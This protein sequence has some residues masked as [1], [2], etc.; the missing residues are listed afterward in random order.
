[1]HSRH[2]R[3]SLA[4]ALLAVMATAMVL[5]GAQKQTEE[6][7]GFAVRRPV[8][9]G[10]CA[11][12][13][14]GALADIV[15]E[16]LLPYGYNAKV[17][18]DCS[19]SYGPPLVAGHENPRHV[20]PESLVISDHSP[21]LPDAPVDFGV[22]S[23]QVLYN[24]YHGLAPYKQ[25]MKNLRLL[26]NLQSPDFLIVAVK[27]DTGIT[28]LSQLRKKRW[29]VRILLGIDGGA[30]T[31]I[32]NYYGLT[33]KEIVSAGGSIASAMSPAERRNFDVV[34]SGGN[35][36][37]APEYNVWYEVSQKYDLTYLQ[38]PNDLLD[39]LAKDF[40]FQRG[41]IPDG[42]LRGITH[43]IATVVRTGTVVFGRSD[44][45]DDFAYTVAKA[46]DVHQALLQWSNLRFSYNIHTVWKDRDVPLA[47]GA[48]RYYRQAGYMK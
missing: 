38:L 27:S 4:A 6:R 5:S 43:P 30:G 41:T 26:A 18:Y 24:T 46:M 42:L 19:R 20:V 8:L 7:Y 14:W 11:T 32:L 16:A 2:A 31:A 10:A 48:A 36:G 47:P 17:C 35:L 12:C 37:N 1:M 9:A 44:M 21:P 45:P 22:T 33:R 13:P 28:D 15:R 34:I 3:F 29:P 25:P 39:K 40:N 23:A